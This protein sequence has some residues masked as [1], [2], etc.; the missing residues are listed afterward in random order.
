MRIPADAKLKSVDFL[1][2]NLIVQLEQGARW[3][4]PV[5]R[6]PALAKAAEDVRRR[7]ELLPDGKGVV[8]PALVLC[9][10]L[11]QLKP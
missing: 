2:G 1:K 6:F 8:W 3:K 5:S 9:V 4:V 10:S 7:Y 11:Q